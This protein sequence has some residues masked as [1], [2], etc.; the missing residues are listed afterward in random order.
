MNLG[1]VFS[2]LWIVLAAIWWGGIVLLKTHDYY[3]CL[4]SGLQMRNCFAINGP[5]IIAVLLPILVLLSGLISRW[6]IRGFR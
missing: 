2:R 3:L 6:I 1:R 4:S 5:P